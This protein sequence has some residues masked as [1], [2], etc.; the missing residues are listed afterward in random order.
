MKINLHVLS[1]AAVLLAAA[2]CA[3]TPHDKGPYSA[4]MAAK[5]SNEAREPIVL[6]DPGVQ[7]SVAF[8]GLQEQALPDGRLQV[9]AH[10]RN[11]EGRRIEVQ[12]NCIFK[13]L[14]GF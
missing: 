1:M 13:D 10:L 6:M 9:L 11:R 3:S 8:Y 7:Y 12:A 14:N 4:Q 5:P 2:G